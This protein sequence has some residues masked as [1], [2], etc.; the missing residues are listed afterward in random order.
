MNPNEKL[1]FDKYVKEHE[2]EMRLKR[3]KKPFRTD[4]LSQKEISNCNGMR[5]V[6]FG[7][8]NNEKIELK[9]E[10]KK[11]PYPTVSVTP[12]LVDRLVKNIVRRSDD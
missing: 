11:K 9:R 2:E 6:F 8:K 7:A 3:E 4:K 5:Q 12:T 1:V 10:D